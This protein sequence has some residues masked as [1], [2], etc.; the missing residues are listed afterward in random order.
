MKKLVLLAAFIVIGGVLCLKAAAPWD[1][2]NQFS[3]GGG[4]TTYGI[5]LNNTGTFQPHTSGN[6]NLGD[7]TYKIG[8]INMSGTLSQSGSVTI[9]GDLTID[10]G[11]TVDDVFNLDDVIV[12]IIGE[13]GTTTIPVAG[14]FIILKSTKSISLSTAVAPGVALFSTATANAG[15]YLTV[16]S[17]SSSKITVPIGVT[18]YVAGSSSPTILNLYDSISYIFD[19][20]YWIQK[21]S[22]VN[23]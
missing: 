22:S 19:G 2:E 17:S 21:S 15:D 5:T 23:N 16:T 1:Q 11:L 7:A 12:N 4:N 14:S 10:G 3:T 18:H 13:G 20:N 6:V 9:G 8:N